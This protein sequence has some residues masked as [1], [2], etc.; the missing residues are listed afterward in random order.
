MDTNSE[1]EVVD[2]VARRNA[3]LAMFTPEAERPE[4]KTITTSPSGRWRLETV[5]FNTGKGYIGYT[6]GQVFDAQTNRLVATIYRNY[7]DMWRLWVENHK[8]TGADYLLTGEDYQGLTIVNLTSGE[9]RSYL[10]EAAGQGWGW[11]IVHAELM[12]D[13]VTL[14]MDGCYWACP[15]EVRVL[16]FSNP[17]DPSFVER[18]LS[19]LLEPL[20]VGG[21]YQLEK[22][23]TGGFT[24]TEYVQRFIPTGEYEAEIERRQSP[25]YDEMHLAKKSGDAARIAAS[26]AA[27]DAH[28]EHYDRDNKSLWEK[29][30]YTRV[31]YRYEN[32]E[33]KVISEWKSDWCLQCETHR[34]AQEQKRSIAWTASMAS[35][36]FVKLIQA[37][38]PNAKFNMGHQSHVD[39]LDGDTNNHYIH[40]KLPLSN[41]NRNA[42]LSWGSEH[43]DLKLELWTRGVGSTNLTFPRTQD[44]FV[45]ALA[46]TQSHLKGDTQES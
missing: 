17:D 7:S 42:Y 5:Q 33:N 29:V 40:Y 6:R 12:P 26:T 32:E 41:D 45:V 8:I 1:T 13:G 35:D 15:Y 24:L 3:I 16:D 43:G 36:P 39:R 21:G 38:N 31:T 18:G 37:E 27:W 30:P 34:A 4:T 11:C 9:M 22:D 20:S 28:F 19:D 2:L 46:A 14:K 10:P 44:G 25:I 23:D